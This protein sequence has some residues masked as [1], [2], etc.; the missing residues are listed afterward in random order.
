MELIET[1]TSTIQ[2]LIE[3]LNQFPKDAIICTHNSH[4]WH[5][6]RVIDINKSDLSYYISKVDNPYDCFGNPIENDCIS[7]FD[8]R[9]TDY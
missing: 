3:Y 8:L 9:K 2:D 6:N 4:A 1:K 5:S 7:I